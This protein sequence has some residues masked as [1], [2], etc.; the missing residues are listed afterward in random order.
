MPDGRQG[1]LKGRACCTAGCVLLAGAVC[2]SAMAV[3][4][5]AADPSDRPPGDQALERL[6]KDR[7]NLLVQTK[8]L[9]RE[10]RELTAV[11]GDFDRIAREKE[12]LLADRERMMRRMGV[13]EEEIE[14]E[15]KATE[16]AQRKGEDLRSRRDDLV[17]EMKRLEKFLAEARSDSGIAKLEEMMTSLK[18]EKEDLNSRFEG[19]QAALTQLQKKSREETTEFEDRLKKSRA[20]FEKE[21]K[22]YQDRLQKLQEEH[23]K[24]VKEKDALGQEL[25][26]LPKAF[27]RMASESGRFTRGAA[28]RHYNL[29]VFYAK[30]GEYR[31]AVAEFEEA[32]RIKPHHAYALYNLGHLYAMHMVDRQKSVHYFREYLKVSPD[33][34]D[35]DL[36]RRYILSWEPMTRK[37]G[38]K[39]Q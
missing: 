2:L 29:G 19:T 14:E 21:I 1:G 11:K 30:N 5:R 24:E 36:V 37:G 34:K 6:R 7:D 31:R 16:R 13:L 22:G 23:A 8:R 25:A 10:N 17:E 9:L 32:L 18:T 26:N 3:P 12:S 28:D 15:K 39:A 4:A 27:T 35:R 33:A 20:E 38:A